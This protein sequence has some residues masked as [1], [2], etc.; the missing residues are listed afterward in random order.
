MSTY[1]IGDVH[2]CFDQFI[3]LLKNLGVETKPTAMS[4]SVSD[5]LSG[6]EYAGSS[7]NT[8]FAQRR[9][10]VSPRFLRM[11]KDILKFNSQVETHLSDN[12][13]CGEMTLTFI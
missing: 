3:R 6:V 9:N 4:F 7:L 13:E 1:V 2:G 8:L 11:T 10:I 12:P 5:A